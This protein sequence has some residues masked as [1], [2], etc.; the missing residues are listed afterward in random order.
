[1]KQAQNKTEDIV[2]GYE[3]RLPIRNWNASLLLLLC[4]KPLRELR[5]PIR[6]WNMVEV[7]T[8]QSFAKELRL[9]IRNWNK[10]GEKTKVE[11]LILNLDYL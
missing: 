10:N 11:N 9:P 8:L 3:L 4:H 6:N 7:D 5:L 1:M 2:K